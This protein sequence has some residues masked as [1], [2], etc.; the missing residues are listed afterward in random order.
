MDLEY[1]EE[2]HDLFSDFPPAPEK[3]ALTYEMLSPRQRELLY[4]FDDSP[5][6]YTSVEKLVPTLDPKQ[7]YVCHYRNLQLYLSLGMKVVKV[8]RIVWFDQ[9]PWLKKYIDFNTNQRTKATSEFGKN[10]FKL[11]NNAVFGKTMEN[12]RN[13]RNIEVTTTDERL[14]KL[15]ARP[16]FHTSNSITADIHVVENYKTSVTLDKTEKVGL[17]ILELSKNP[18]TGWHYGYIKKL[19]PG[20]LSTLLFSDTDSLCYR[21]RTK[22]V[23]AD[24]LAHA[25]EFDWSGYPP[26]HPV[27]NGMSEKDVA[28][29]RMRNKKVL[30]KMKDELD[31]YRMSEFVGV[32]AKCYSFEI[33]ERDREAYF[34]SKRS[35]MK[36]KGISSVALKHQV[37]HADY[38][39]CVLESQRKYVSTQSF[40]SYSHEI[41]TIHQVKLA[42]IN[43]DDK[44]WMCED[45]AATLPHGHYLTRT[46]NP[47]N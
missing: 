25:D 34:A 13:R 18:I 41:Y 20:P 40:R 3:R 39:K 22:D 45:G 8:H 42:L 14:F 9:S 44:R 10:F 12:V 2:L 29:L 38:R 32:R 46:T 26:T 16:T 33:D 36:N 4:M 6:R 11:M 37:T 30:L 1:P 47:H 23:Y 31:G 43:F 21:I 7:N 28:E 35:T 15:G 5:E 24:M 19:Y 27:F 17:A